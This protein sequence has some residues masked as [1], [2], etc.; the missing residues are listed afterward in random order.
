MRKFD[1]ENNKDISPDIAKIQEEVKTIIRRFGAIVAKTRKD[2]EM[3][4]Q[5]LSQKSGVSIG[6]ISDLENGKDKIPNLYTLI[7]LA[8][9]LEIKNDEFLRTIFGEVIHKD[10]TQ[11]DSRDMLVDALVAYGVPIDVAA[12][13]LVG[14][15]LSYGN[16]SIKHKTNRF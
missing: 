10:P 13:I 11:K 14:I 3:K 12:N 2:K 9:T 6:V 15:D 1:I 8:K 5:E 16:H 4:L 7:A